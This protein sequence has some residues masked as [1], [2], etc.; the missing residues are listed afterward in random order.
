VVGPETPAKIWLDRNLG[1][2]QVATSAT[3][4]LAYGSLF[5][6]GRAADGHQLINHTTATAAT[7]QNSSTL[8]LSASDTAPDNLF[9]KAP[10]TP[11]DWRSPAGH[12]V[13]GGYQ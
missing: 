2:T 6:W 11:F 3:D 10:S 9:I 1:A 13:G 12:S 7:A 8:T 4:W 5:Q